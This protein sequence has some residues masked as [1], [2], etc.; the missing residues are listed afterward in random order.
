VHQAGSSGRSNLLTLEVDEI[1][2]NCRFFQSN[3]L[4]FDLRP[5]EVLN[6]KRFVALSDFML[7]LGQLLEKHVV[8]TYQNGKDDAV[9]LEYRPGD[10]ALR[11]LKPNWR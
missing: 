1:Y 3:D 6:E 11:Y 10:G 7:A 8:L 5:E 9:F 4:E 2:V